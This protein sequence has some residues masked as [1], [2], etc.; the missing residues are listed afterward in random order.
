[1]EPMNPAP[2]VTAIFSMIYSLSIF[3][4]TLQAGGILSE[5]GL[6]G[7]FKASLEWGLNPHGAARPRSGDVS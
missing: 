1:L 4:G 7:Q 2:P 3:W 6:Q 5:K